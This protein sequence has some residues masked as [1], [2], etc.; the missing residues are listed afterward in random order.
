MKTD[1]FP[2]QK[3]L[4]SHLMHNPP[5]IFVGNFRTSSAIPVSSMVTQEGSVC[6]NIYDLSLCVYVYVCTHHVFAWQ[7]F[8]SQLE[9]QQKA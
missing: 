6:M 3:K 2:L 1:S 5:P 9:M 8:V 7:S 4:K